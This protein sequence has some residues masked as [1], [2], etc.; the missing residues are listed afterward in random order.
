MAAGSSPPP[1]FA[2]LVQIVCG[3]PCSSQ[4][5]C[6]CLQ[7]MLGCIVDFLSTSFANFLCVFLIGPLLFSTLQHLH[8]Q[9]AL[10]HTFH[11]V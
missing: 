5:Y 7:F 8:A 9:A 10:V 3:Q 1:P 2:S 4:L 11:N 6:V